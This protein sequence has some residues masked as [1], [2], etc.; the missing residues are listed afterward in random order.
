[1]TE[2]GPLPFTVPP[3]PSEA[4]HSWLTRLSVPY[5][6][7]PWQLLHELGVGT[8]AER[9]AARKHPVQAFLD[10]TD[11]RRLAHLTH[12]D[13]SRF[14]L[15]RL[16]P[17]AWTLASDDWV[18]HCRGCEQ[19]DRRNGIATYERSAWRNAAR[20]FCQRHRAPL[21][22]G[23]AAVPGDEGREEAATP[24]TELETA[25]AVQLGVWGA[26]EQKVW[27]RIGIGGVSERSQL[28][29]CD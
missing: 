28:A 7:K 19:E 25:I 10:V 18:M 17:P 20:T 27:L 2:Q 1:M 24:L 15:D 22:L 21:I 9:N 8:F 12:T 26:M 3:Y 16:C 23:I 5:R 4:L 11:L 29:P 14:G 6:L 13:P